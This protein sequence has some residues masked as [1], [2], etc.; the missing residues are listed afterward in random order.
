MTAK[1]E[2]AAGERLNSDSS[3][4]LYLP[5]RSLAHLSAQAIQVFAAIFVL[6]I[7]F[8]VP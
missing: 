5:F 3:P 7:A 2:T 1:R 4:R 8:A 6:E